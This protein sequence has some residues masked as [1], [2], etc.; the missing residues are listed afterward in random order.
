M[1]LAADHVLPADHAID[2]MRTG[3]ALTWSPSPGRARVTG[4]VRGLRPS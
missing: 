4:S 2:S 1:T 3:G